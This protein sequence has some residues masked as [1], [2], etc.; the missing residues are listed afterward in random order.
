MLASNLESNVSRGFSEVSLVH[1]SAPFGIIP[2]FQDPS[3]FQ[4]AERFVA[5]LGLADICVSC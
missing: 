1:A 5:S 2:G 3:W 4:Q